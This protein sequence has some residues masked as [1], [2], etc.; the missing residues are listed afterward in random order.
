MYWILNVY[1]RFFIRK[2]EIKRSNEEMGKANWFKFLGII[3]DSH[4]EFGKLGKEQYNQSRTICHTLS[5]LKRDTIYL[6]LRLLLI[7]VS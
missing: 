4:L 1:T 2:K 3:L 6:A 7:W 5:H